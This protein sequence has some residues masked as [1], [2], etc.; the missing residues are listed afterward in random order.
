M[1]CKTRQLKYMKMQEYENKNNSRDKHSGGALAQGGA[2]D[3]RRSQWGL[4]AS[5]APTGLEGNHVGPWFGFDL[6]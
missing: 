6:T 5:E 2:N 1:K 3:P 4:V